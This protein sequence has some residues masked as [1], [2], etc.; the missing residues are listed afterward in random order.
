MIRIFAVL[1]LSSIALSLQTGTFYSIRSDLT[2]VE[3]KFPEDIDILAW[4]VFDN[5]V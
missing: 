2:I 3:G 1:Y 5:E 4:G